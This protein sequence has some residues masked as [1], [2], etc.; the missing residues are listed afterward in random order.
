MPIQ[1]LMISLFI[2]I[3]ITGVTSPP[4]FSIDEQQEAERVTYVID[5]GHSSLIFAINHF[6]L[7]YVYGRFNQVQGEFI[8]EGDKPI[9]RGFTFKVAAD[10]IDTNHRERDAHLKGPDFFDCQQFPE[11]RF[12]TL[13]IQDGE[14]EF[15][16]TGE[17][18]LLDQTKKI[19]FPMR[20]VGR[21]KDPFGKERAGF[22]AR[23]TILRSDFGMDNMLGAIGDQVSITFAFEGVKKE[24]QEQP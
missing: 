13:E 6:G 20:M 24:T 9:Q 18:S 8:L 3:L 19:T 21:G 1:K 2:L 15:L 12:A 11:I 5:N 22:F 16:V 14:E 23:F 10:S 4:L 7:S 17:L